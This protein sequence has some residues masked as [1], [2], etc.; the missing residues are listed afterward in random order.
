MQRKTLGIPSVSCMTPNYGLLPFLKKK[1]FSKGKNCL[2]S[3]IIIDKMNHTQ[4][5]VS[6]G[7]PRGYGKG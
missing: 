3:K 2:K 7:I 5:I 4:I 1:T 6:L